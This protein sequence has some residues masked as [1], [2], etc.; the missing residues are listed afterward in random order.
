VF[1]THRLGMVRGVYAGLMVVATAVSPALLGLAL[2][3]GVSLRAM[4]VGTVAYVLLA[5]LV[6]APRLGSR[7]PSRRS[8]RRR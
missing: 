5:P 2:A 6:A 4:A 3:A 8:G 7:S 1:G